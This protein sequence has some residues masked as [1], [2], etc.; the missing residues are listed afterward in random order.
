MNDEDAYS[1]S[2]YYIVQNYGPRQLLPCNSSHI[3]HFI[4]QLNVHIIVKVVPLT[5]SWYYY[6]T[7]AIERLLNYS[8]STF[9]YI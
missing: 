3:E 1:A 2:L 9:T 6:V 5:G 7:G 4:L 8:F